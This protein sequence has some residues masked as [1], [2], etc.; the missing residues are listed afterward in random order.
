MEEDRLN[1]FKYYLSQNYFNRNAFSLFYF[2][3][4]IHNKMFE[5]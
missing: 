2:C 5:N 1:N 4:V 3:G